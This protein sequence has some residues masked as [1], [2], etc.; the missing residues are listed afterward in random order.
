M[1]EGTYQA[2]LDRLT[3]QHYNAM[4]IIKSDQGE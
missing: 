2:I 4:K 3:E 1:K